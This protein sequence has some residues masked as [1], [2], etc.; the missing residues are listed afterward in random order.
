MGL[1]KAIGQKVGILK[2]EIPAS[3]KDL[4]VFRD[5]LKI[6]GAI[7]D[8]QRGWGTQI[9]VDK[10]WK[11]V[12]YSIALFHISK[13]MED[14]LDHYENS[15]WIQSSYEI[16]KYSNEIRQFVDNTK[17]H[18]K[19]GIISLA[20]AKRESLANIKAEDRKSLDAHSIALLSSKIYNLILFGEDT[21]SRVLTGS[22]T[23]ASMALCDEA[24][25]IINE[26]KNRSYYE[27]L[28]KS[29]NEI[30]EIQEFVTSL[31]NEIK[32]CTKRIHERQ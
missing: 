25:V 32:S 20:E 6:S 18:Y 7:S 4:K 29:T 24:T 16:N 9:L 2:E 1:F 17:K 8:I 10:Y 5:V 12:P 26:I 19:E 14:E 15:L 22:I 28:K 3:D 30:E 21:S 11:I 13:E 27:E 23:G 31:N